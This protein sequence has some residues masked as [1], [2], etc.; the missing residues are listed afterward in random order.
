MDVDMD[1]AL[2][3][4]ASQLE[5]APERLEKLKAFVAQ[6]QQVQLREKGE[7]HE[8]V[9]LA[10]QTVPNRPLQM[11]RLSELLTKAS[12]EEWFAELVTAAVRVKNLLS[13]AEEEPG[14]VDASKLSADAEKELYGELGKL[15]AAAKSAIAGCDWEK[16]AATMAELAPVIA[17]FFNDVLVMDKDPQ[18]RAN[19]LALLG[20]CQNFFMHIGDFSILK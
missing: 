3:M 10:M 17:Q 19:R 12:G 7:S 16:L 4:A 8:A 14:A 2:E 13:K 5:L 20:E 15:T 18:I 9:A 1:E 6:R 11:F